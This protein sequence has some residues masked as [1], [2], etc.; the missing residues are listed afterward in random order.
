MLTACDE[1]T[2]EDVGVD[3]TR[4]GTATATYRGT[5]VV[6]QV[7]DTDDGRRLVVAVD[8]GA[9]AVLAGPVPLAP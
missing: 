7:F 9:C 5:P 1:L 8:A 3:G 2:P 4:S 6:V